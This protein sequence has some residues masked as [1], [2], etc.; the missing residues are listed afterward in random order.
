MSTEGFSDRDILPGGIIGHMVNINSEESELL[1]RARE[2]DVRALSRI[3]DRYYPE[4]YRYAYYRTGEDTVAEDIASEVFLRLLVGLRSGRPP[5][6]TLRGWLFGVASHLVVDHFRHQSRLSQLD[7]VTANDSPQ[8][9]AEKNLRHH[10]VQKA[11]CKL[12]VEQQEVLALRF[13][14]GFSVEETAQLIGKSVPAVKSL[15]FRAVEALRSQLG[16]VE[17]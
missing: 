11:I 17:L 2:M 3:H 10:E 5:Q 15:Q 6:T 8:A 16:E 1:L 4:I 7:I 9:E 14:D 13:G 12:T